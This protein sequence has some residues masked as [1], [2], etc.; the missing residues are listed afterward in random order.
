MAS[1]DSNSQITLS[2]FDGIAHTTANM[3]YRVVNP[4]TFTVKSDW[5]TGDAVIDANNAQRRIFSLHSDGYIRIDSLTFKNTT[6]PTCQAGSQEFTDTTA[7]GAIVQGPYHSNVGIQVVNCKFSNIANNA[8]GWMAQYGVISGNT[9]TNISGHCVFGSEGN[10]LIENNVMNGS[11]RGMNSFGRY[12]VFRYNTVKNMRSSFCGWHADG[13][14][15]IQSGARDRNYAWVYGNTFENNSQH[16]YVVYNYCALGCDYQ[17]FG[18]NTFINYTGSGTN[19]NGDTGSGDVGLI[20]GRY[21]YVL[22]N[23]FWAS[24]V[25]SEKWNFYGPLEVGNS[26]ITV[27]NNLF[28]N[29]PTMNWWNY[30]SYK[31]GTTFDYNAYYDASIR[32]VS[33]DNDSDPTWNLSQWQALGYDTHGPHAGGAAMSAV[34]PY[35]TNESILGYDMHLT[36]STPVSVKT[37]GSNLSMYF[38]LDKDKKARS[39]WSLGAYAYVQTGDITI[40]DAPTGLSVK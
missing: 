18:N 2:G 10:G 36:A 40:P 35:V 24:P 5:G 22:N 32:D 37:G 31:T 8:I 25:C 28:I 15:P 30:D 6:L 29:R 21:A 4:M 33:H 19:C 38:T 16:I 12:D 7:D 27:R 26:N 11:M 39:S 34:N 13:I 23:T 3:H 20:V 9:F 1:V 17:V 14:G